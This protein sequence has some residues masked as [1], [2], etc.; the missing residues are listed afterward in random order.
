[1]PLLSIWNSNPETVSQMSIEQI[2]ATAGNG[3]LL[4][5]SDCSSELREYLS[6]VTS[7]KLAIYADYCL[8]TKF[9]NNGKILQDVVNELGRRLDYQ[10]KNGRYQGSQN[11]IGNDGLWL[12]PEGHHLVIEVKTTDTYSI[13]VD[14]IAQYRKSLRDQNEINEENSMLLVVGRYET[15]QMEAQVRGSRHAWDMRLISVDSLVNLVNLKENTDDEATISKIRSILIP[16]EYTR[17]DRLIDVMFTTAKDVENLIESET[18][19]DEAQENVADEKG[20]WVFT[21]TAIIDEKRTNILRTLGEINKTKLVKKSRA[22]YWSADR[23]VGIACT[24]SKKYER[25]A[26]DYWY[27]YHPHWDEFLSKTEKSYF[28]LGCVDIDIAFAIPHQI[29][30][31]KLPELNTT[32]KNGKTYWHIQIPKTPENQYYLNCQKTGEHVDLSPFIVKTTP[33]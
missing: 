25:K 31:T 8:T 21:E 2:V 1:M 3:R 23:S 26:F 6:Q 7:E 10:V 27:A 13:S 18:P 14:T 17:L 32:T 15:G 12:S 9:D 4:D 22:L 28:V 33:V 30:K 24:I 29:I 11:K 16:M 5:D 20:T 19:H